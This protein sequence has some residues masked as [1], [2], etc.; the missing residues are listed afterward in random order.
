MSLSAAQIERGHLPKPAQRNRP[1]P[2]PAVLLARLAVDQT[3]Q[4]QGLARSLLFYALATAVRLARELACF[5]VITH[6][7][8][9]GVRAFY[10]R[11]GFEELPCDPVRAMAVRIAD[12]EKAVLGRDRGADRVGGSSCRIG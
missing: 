8:D 11:F 2:I 9:E 6:P 4:G 1:D 7:L 3:R 5:C 10:A 12:L